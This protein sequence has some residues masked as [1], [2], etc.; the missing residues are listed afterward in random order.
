M[1]T[2]FLNFAVHLFLE[3]NHERIK[4]LKIEIQSCETGDEICEAV[5]KHIDELT[6][7]LDMDSMWNGTNIH[8]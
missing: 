1:E 5:Q 7:L 6:E 8:T 4:K 2:A 3:N